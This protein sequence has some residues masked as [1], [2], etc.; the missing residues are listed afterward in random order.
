MQRPDRPPVGIGIENDDL[1]TVAAAPPLQFSATFSCDPGRTRVFVVESRLSHFFASSSRDYIVGLFCA[2]L[3]RS[4]VCFVQAATFA[5]R[6]IS[7]K[8]KNATNGTD[9]DQR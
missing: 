8:G 2:A 7:I 4:S 3:G 1:R 9:L 6:P 5:G